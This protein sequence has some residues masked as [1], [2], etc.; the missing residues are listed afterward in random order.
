MKFTP[1]FSKENIDTV[2][3]QTKACPENTQVSISKIENG[4]IELY[5]IAINDSTIETIDN[6]KKV[7]GIG[8]ITKLFTSTLLATMAINGELNI[9]DDIQDNLRIKLKNSP[10]I[11]YKQLANHTSG[12]PKWP[13]FSEEHPYKGYNYQDLEHYLQNNLYLE[14]KKDS[15]NYSNLG[16]SLLGYTLSKILNKSYEELLQNMILKELGMNSTTTNIDKIKE[17][18][19]MPTRITEAVP[20][21]MI[22]AGGMFSSVK[23]LS[24]FAIASFDNENKSLMKTQRQTFHYHHTE[25]FDEVSFSMGLGWSI[26]EP[27]STVVIHMHDGATDGYTSSIMLD[28]QNKNAVII[29]SN[30]SA[31]DKNS[32]NIGAL[33]NSLM[34]SMYH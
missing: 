15:F 3:K 20:S 28:I 2:Y 32:D 25:L 12:L 6:H 1:A 18:L 30:I 29:L 17:K 34:K 13:I 5:G 8:S 24:K 26:I 23:D 10:E 27:N 19:V 14:G 7:F 22:S 33:A 31:D 11:T 4:I 21:A 9:D 16:A